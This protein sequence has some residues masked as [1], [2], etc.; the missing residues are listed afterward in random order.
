MRRLLTDGRKSTVQK[1]QSSL[2]MSKGVAA[3]SD[4]VISKEIGRKKVELVTVKPTLDA[5]DFSTSG[6]AYKKRDHH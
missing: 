5:V 6:N 2:E 4:V 1:R 3:A